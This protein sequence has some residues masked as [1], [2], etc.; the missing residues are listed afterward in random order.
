MRRLRVVLV[1]SRL[2]YIKRLSLGQLRQHG[3][4]LKPLRRRSR[5]ETR[6]ATLIHKLP[7]KLHIRHGREALRLL[8]C[9][10]RRQ[11]R[12]Q[13]QLLPGDSFGRRNLA[14]AS[15]NIRYARETFLEVGRLMG[16]RFTLADHAAL[17]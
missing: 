13:T 3:R 17:L 9:V 6:A 16:H 5:L 12:L 1:H 10:L 15:G 7:R 4:I 8:R 11:R 14:I 2:H